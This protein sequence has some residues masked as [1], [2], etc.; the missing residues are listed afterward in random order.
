MAQ[1]EALA[2]VTLIIDPHRN[3]PADAQQ[4]VHNIR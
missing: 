4:Y 3:F 2:T 1:D